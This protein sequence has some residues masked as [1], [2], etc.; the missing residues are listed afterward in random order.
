MI[1]SFSSSYVRNNGKLLYC[2]YTIIHQWHWFVGIQSDICQAEKVRCNQKTKSFIAA[3]YWF[4]SPFTLLY[5]YSILSF[6]ALNEYHG[7]AYDD[8]K[9]Y[10]VL[11]DAVC[12][13]RFVHVYV[14]CLLLNLHLFTQVIDRF[15]SPDVNQFI[16]ICIE[17][18]KFN[19]QTIW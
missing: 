14:V 12:L 10:I 13:H 5:H 3:F 9:S 17:L 7:V 6:F 11:K 16:F 19:L 1:C 15:V 2:M 18:R 8:I 4:W